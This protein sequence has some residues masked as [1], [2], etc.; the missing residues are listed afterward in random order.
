ML[1]NLMMTFIFLIAAVLALSSILLAAEPGTAP[2]TTT[3][4]AVREAEGGMKITEVR[5]GSPQEFAVKPGDRVWVHYAGRLDNGKEFDSSYKRGEAIDFIVGTGRVIKGW[6]VGIQGMKLGDK[7]LLV[8]PPNMGYGDR[9]M[10]GG[11]I[12][13]NSTLTFDVELVGVYRASAGAR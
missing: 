10:G 12:P 4:P 5:A 7:R 3:Q 1:K 9:D 8:I 11:L 2:A 13:A 6:D